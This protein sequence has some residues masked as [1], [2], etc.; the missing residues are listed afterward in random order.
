M[1]AET[2]FKAEDTGLGYWCV[3]HVATNQVVATGLNEIEARKIAS[4]MRESKPTDL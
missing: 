1:T 3:V 4:G 2:M